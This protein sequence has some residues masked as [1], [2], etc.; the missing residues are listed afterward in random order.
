MKKNSKTLFQIGIGP[1]RQENDGTNDRPLWRGNLWEYLFEIKIIKNLFF[2]SGK[3]RVIP[4]SSEA[5]NG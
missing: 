5:G 1:W 3:V 4:V 2:T